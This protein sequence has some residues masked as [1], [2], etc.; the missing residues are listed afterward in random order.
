MGVP[1]FTVDIEDLINAESPNFLMK[2]PNLVGNA[3]TAYQSSNVKNAIEY[4]EFLAIRAYTD[5]LYK[6]IN[7]AL[8]S[9]QA[10]KWAV[11]SSS[12][13]SGLAKLA[14]H[15][16]HSQTGTMT[17]GLTLSDSQVN[18][19]FPDDGTFSDKT[20]MSSSYDPKKSFDGNVKLT[21]D[22]DTP[23]AKVGDISVYGDGE[24]E[25]LFGPDGKFDVVSKSK[26]SDGNWKIHV[27]EKK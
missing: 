7:P 5:D 26:Q 6:G 23:Q 21:I 22:T 13:E 18:D 15:P 16:V 3:N 11:I 8:R 27:K 17:R 19:I 12:A 4:H 24:A 10:G 25:V 14:Q 9:G 1:S 20:F 2:D